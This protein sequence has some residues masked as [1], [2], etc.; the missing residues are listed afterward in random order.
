MGDEELSYRDFT[1][2]EE[3]NFEDFMNSRNLI[4]FMRRYPYLVVGNYYVMKFKDDYD[5]PNEE[6]IIMMVGYFLGIDDRPNHNETLIFSINEGVTLEDYFS[7]RSVRSRIENG[8]F[9][10]GLSMEDEFFN[11]TAYLIMQRRSRRRPVTQRPPSRRRQSRIRSQS[12][13]RR[14]T[15]TRGRTPTRRQSRSHGRIRH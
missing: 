2:L 15:Q 1:N 13:T 9:Q 8:I 5:D 6:P 12:P 11:M 14:G 10:A 3:R 7:M 4:R